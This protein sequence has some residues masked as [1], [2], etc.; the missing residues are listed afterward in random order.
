MPGGRVYN[1]QKKVSQVNELNIL[2]MS[3]FTCARL[4]DCS[5]HYDSSKHCKKVEQ[6]LAIIYVDG[7]GNGTFAS[8]LDSAYTIFITVKKKNIYI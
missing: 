1:V 6:E 3:S 7:P 2:D 5:Q 8:G 4:E